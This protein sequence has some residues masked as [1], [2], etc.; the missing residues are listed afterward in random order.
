[1]DNEKSQSKWKNTPCACGCGIELSVYRGRTRRYIE[2]HYKRKTKK[3]KN[4]NMI[5]CACGCGKLRPNV[6]DAGHQRRF[7][8]GHNTKAL[9]K[10]PKERD[11][12]RENIITQK[13][14][15]WKSP[16]YRDKL[17]KVRTELW[18]DPWYKNKTLKA[19][20]QGINTKPTKPEQ[21]I[22]NLITKHNL[23]YKYVGDGD[24]WIYGLNPD[25]IQSNG[26]KKIIEVFGKIYHDV[27][28]AIRG[29]PWKSSEWGR[30]AIFSQ[31]GYATLIL[32]DDEILNNPDDVLEKIMKFEEP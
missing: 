3:T 28:S 6:D 32:W 4:K 14:E 24:V 30:K 20:R 13:K 27:E 8:I 18:Q 5:P 16:G 22:I 19:M 17:S 9:W 21:A 7:I 23:P 15:L 10:D 29:V 31:L 1:M 25:F 26:K 11:K 2:G 12:R